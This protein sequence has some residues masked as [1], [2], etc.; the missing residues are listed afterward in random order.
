MSGPDPLTAWT[1]R[2]EAERV[3]LLRFARMRLRDPDAAEDAVQDTLLAALAGRTPFLGKSSLRTWLTSI[4]NHKI[5]DTYRRNAGDRARASGSG[6]DAGLAATSDGPDAFDFID[7]GSNGPD[8]TLEN[9]QLGSSLMTA[10]RKLP[11]RQRDVF[12]MYQLSGCSGDE[13]AATV[14]VSNSNVWVMLHR[15]RKLLRNE[16]RGIG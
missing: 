7:G 9:K 11:A 12:M 6:F 2:I 1:G 3:Y 10:I 5:M 16:L 14:G 4:L 15:A 13:I 8:A